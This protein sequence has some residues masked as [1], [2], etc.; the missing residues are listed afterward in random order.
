MGNWIP[1]QPGGTNSESQFVYASPQPEGFISPMTWAIEDD[2][3]ERFAAAGFRK[4]RI[5]FKRDKF[6]F[7]ARHA[8]SSTNCRR[9]RAGP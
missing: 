8:P 1:N 2:V 6:T 9:T 5:A 4:T 3:I 7:W